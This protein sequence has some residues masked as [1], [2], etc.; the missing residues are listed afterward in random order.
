MVRSIE[1]LA[2]RDSN[3]EHHPERRMK[4]PDHQVECD[5]ETEMD[6]VDA[7]LERNGEQDRHQNRQRGR[8]KFLQ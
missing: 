4:Q 7:E 3:E 6:R 8:G 5:D 2:I 1:S